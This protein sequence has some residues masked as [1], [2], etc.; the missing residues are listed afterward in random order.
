MVLMTSAT[1]NLTLPTSNPISPIFAFY[2]AM[3]DASLTHTLTSLSPREQP[4]TFTNVLFHGMEDYAVSRTR[5]NLILALRYYA[6]TAA[7]QYGYVCLL[8]IF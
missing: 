5:V 1:C 3:R 6:H 4:L 8:D 2:L 7:R